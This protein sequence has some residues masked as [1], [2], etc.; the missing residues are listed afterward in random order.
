MKN[1]K[2]ELDTPCLT[3]NIDTLEDNLAAMQAAARAATVRA[4]GPLIEDCRQRSQA[5]C[6][7]P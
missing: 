5:A 6:Q 3:I 1:Y 4:T 7:N 2:H